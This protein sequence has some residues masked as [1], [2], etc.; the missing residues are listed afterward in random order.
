MPIKVRR[1]TTSRA[2]A[3]SASRLSQ[4]PAGRRPAPAGS[5]PPAVVSGIV[6]IG[7]VPRPRSR[8]RVARSMRTSCMTSG[9]T[10]SSTTATATPRSTACL[11]I[12]HGHGVAV[13]GGRR[14]EDPEVGGREQLDGQ[15][16]VGL[17]DGV[18][19]GRVDD[20]QAGR[21][22]VVRHQPQRGD[23]RRVDVDGLGRLG[24]LAGDPGEARAAPAGRGRRPSRTGGARARASG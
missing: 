19:V 1:T 12:S 5:P 20:R 17:D 8:S 6:N 21:D 7:D 14:D 4:P 18:D 10:R 13:A 16:A 9:G 2:R 22:A 3:S 11:S 15:V 23:A 24:R